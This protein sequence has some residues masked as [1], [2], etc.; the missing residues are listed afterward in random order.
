MT[1]AKYLVV[2]M[3]LAA[4]CAP[5]APAGSPTPSATPSGPRPITRLTA[6]FGPADSPRSGKTEIT[7]D[8][9]RSRTRYP[10][11]PGSELELFDASD[12]TTQVRCDSRGCL[13]FEVLPAPDSPVSAV[14]K[15]CANAEQTG[16]GEFIGRRTTIWTCTP[17]GGEPTE[18][19]FDA[20]YPETML[21]ATLTAGYQWQAESFEV[22]VQVPDDFF[23]IDRPGLKW[24]KPTPTKVTPPKPGKTGAVLPAVGGGTIRMTDYT[25]GPAL[26][27]IGGED[28]LRG[29]LARIDRV[30]SGS[31]PKLAGV[32][33]LPG[34]PRDSLPGQPFG[35]PVGLYD[36]EQDG[37]SWLDMTGG[38][39]MPTAVFCRGV[40]KTCTAIAVPEL[41]DAELAA[42]IAKLG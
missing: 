27:V 2:L 5:V 13:R 31:L 8:G 39:Q 21:K 23:A 11:N 9:V 17:T 30:H 37:E 32:L 42:E 14:E 24:R 15:Q 18:A 20:E 38:Q 26:I 22:G 16:T 4:G 3:L 12:G 29:A 25:Q 40:G 1:S 28:E 19:V 10:D 7:T 6:Y 41:A 36:T 35:V 34:S 33:Q